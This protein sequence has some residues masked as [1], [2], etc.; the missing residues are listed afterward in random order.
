MGKFT[1]ILCLFLFL[2]FVCLTGGRNCDFLYIFEI[3]GDLSWGHLGHIYSV[4]VRVRV[5][6]YRVPSARELMS[7]L[8]SAMEFLDMADMGKFYEYSSI[9]CLFVCLTGDLLFIYITRARPRGRAGPGT[10]TAVPGYP[11]GS[12]TVLYRVSGRGCFTVS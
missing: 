3:V 10:A 5:D 12:G 2:L 6:G 11:T 8:P 4:R 1:S 7:S 9:L